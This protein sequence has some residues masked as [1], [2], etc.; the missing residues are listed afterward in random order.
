MRIHPVHVD[1]LFLDMTW[2]YVE[3]HMNSVDDTDSMG[4]DGVRTYV[5]KLLHIVTVLNPVIFSNSYCTSCILYYA[6][7]VL[8]SISTVLALGSRSVHPSATCM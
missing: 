8:Y 4:T 5:C 6:H 1:I 3:L 2:Y 7:S